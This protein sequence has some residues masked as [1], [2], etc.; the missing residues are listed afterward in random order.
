MDPP[1]TDGGIERD[2]LEEVKEGGPMHHCNL[3]D[4]EVIHKIA[5]AFL[6]G[7]ATA[8]VDNTTGGLFKSP[9]SVAVEARKEMVDSLIQRSETFVAEAIILEGEAETEVP[10]HPFDI[11]S[12]FIDDFASSKR[13]FFSRVSGWLL[14]DR[15]EDKIDEF[16]QEM[17]LNG[18][19]MIGRRETVAQTLLK[20]VDFKD[21]F[22]CNKKFNSADELVEHLPQCRFR[23]VHCP[24]EGC[25]DQ[26]SAGNS[27]IHDAVC[28]FKM[29]PCEQNCSD[30]IMRR[31]MDRHCI[32][33]CPMKQVNCPFSSVGCESSVPRSMLEQH[34]LENVHA[35]V[36][37]ILQSIYKEAA[38]EDLKHRVDQ[39]EEVSYY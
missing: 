9:A 31:D 12:D 19:W 21:A 3:F 10:E 30:I 7:L 24:H 26:F 4:A 33:V 25:D 35:H 28:P 2:K 16:V 18:F 17:E 36:L 39:L 8:C 6:P 13:N 27:E 15:R 1:P 32:T 11:I 5:E 38:T 34:K 20:N 29:L 14:S 37:S 22:H 23:T